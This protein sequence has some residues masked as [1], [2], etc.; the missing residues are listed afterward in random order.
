MPPASAITRKVFG[1][2]VDA[3]QAQ[4]ADRGLD[5]QGA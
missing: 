3:G 5:P 2:E 1:I 4:I